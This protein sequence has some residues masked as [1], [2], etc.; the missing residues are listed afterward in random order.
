M[1]RTA[2]CLTGLALTAV[3]CSLHWSQLLAEEPAADKTP[4][5]AKAPT[6]EAPASRG[7]VSIADSIATAEQ[8]EEALDRPINVSFRDE[9]LSKVLESLD[10]QIK[11]QI[12]IDKAALAEEGIE[13]DAPV[14]LQLNNTRA[15]QVLDSALQPLKLDYIVRDGV[16]QITTR[17]LA[18]KTLETRVYD[19]GPLLSIDRDWPS[20]EATITTTIYPSAWDRSGAQ[21]ALHL[22]GNT[23]VV[24]Q[25]QHAHRQLRQLLADL[26]AA[27]KLAAARPPVEELALRTYTVGEQP[28]TELVLTL[29][30]MVSPKSWQTAGGSGEIRVVGNSLFIRQTP[31][32]HRALAQLLAPLKPQPPVHLHSPP[33]MVP[34]TW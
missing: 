15:R 13:T 23:L 34:G 10:Q 11:I 12:R 2:L 20:L 18:D 28:A 25:N 3:V 4:P 22:A 32:V 27:D 33:R 7:I 8:I 1:S 16:L 21:G 24:L 17:L 5:A 31:A 30:E 6:R 14:N 9:R 26:A 19:V 29:Q